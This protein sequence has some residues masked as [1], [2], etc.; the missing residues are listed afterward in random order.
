M[1]FD[2]YDKTRKVTTNGGYWNMQ[3]GIQVAKQ[4]IRN[5]VVDFFNFIMK[6]LDNPKDPRRKV[7]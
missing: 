4:R 6:Q 2:N 7:V 5:Y 1:Y 3:G